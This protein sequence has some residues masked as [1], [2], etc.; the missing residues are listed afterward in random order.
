MTACLLSILLHN[1]IE[2]LGQMH[3]VDMLYQHFQ[4][5]LCHA[6]CLT[7]HSKVNLREPKTYQEQT[8]K[9]KLSES[10]VSKPCSLF[11]LNW[12]IPIYIHVHDVMRVCALV[13][14]YRTICHHQQIFLNVVTVQVS[15]HLTMILK[16]ILYW[17]AKLCCWFRD[18]ISNWHIKNIIFFM[19]TSRQ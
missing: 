3:G 18:K 15:L 7:I 9:V 10:V 17:W 5:V 19:N 8:S 2:Y 1:Y 11:N 4:D 13:L 16:L 12:N 14:Y 6:F